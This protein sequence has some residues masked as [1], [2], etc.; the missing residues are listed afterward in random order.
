[1]D[2]QLTFRAMVFKKFR[3]EMVRFFGTAFAL[4]NGIFYTVTLVV[5][6]YFVLGKTYAINSSLGLLLDA[7]VVGIP[8]FVALCIINL[9]RA[10]YLAGK[11]LEDENKIFLEKI[12]GFEKV[13]STKK[14]EIIDVNAKL[15]TN[16]HVDVEARILLRNNSS[17]IMTGYY[18][19]VEKIQYSKEPFDA[20]EFIPFPE[21]KMHLV[22]PGIAPI[23]YR[24]DSI[25]PYDN[26]Q[27]SVVK[28]ISG[29]TGFKFDTQESD[30]FNVFYKMGTYVV[31]VRIGGVFDGVGISK[32][33]KL[34]IL[35]YG[36]KSLDITNYVDLLEKS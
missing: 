33:I 30:H 5:M 15:V 9:L 26:F 8:Y 35:Y 10:P 17:S 6:R 20:E 3:E 16:N 1:M 29:K 28:T 36:P 4:L 21:D 23:A 34:Y 12:S 24:T 13:L 2:K 27:I 14:I 31:T 22:F 32:R 25:S 7:I 11:Q 19:V 18:A